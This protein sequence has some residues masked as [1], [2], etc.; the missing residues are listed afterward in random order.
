MARRCTIDNSKSVLVGNKVSHSNH[1]TKKRFCPNVQKYLMKSQVLDRV[2]SLKVATKSIRSIEHNH[3]LD[4][5]LTNTPNRKLS[6]QAIKIK[7]LI[8]KKK[9]T[10]NQPA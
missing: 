10:T 5:F 7:K 9:E 6:I 4:S 1:K 8:I 3:G 2:F